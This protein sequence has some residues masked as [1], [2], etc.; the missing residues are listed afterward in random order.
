MR[1]WSAQRQIAG[2]FTESYDC[3]SCKTVLAVVEVILAFYLGRSGFLQVPTTR[4]S[5]KL[6]RIEIHKSHAPSCP[7]SAASGLAPSMPLL[8]DGHVN[9]LQ[10]LHRHNNSVRR[11]HG[12]PIACTLKFGSGQV[13]RT[14][15]AH[16]L[17][18]WEEASGM[19]QEKK[20]KGCTNATS[21]ML[22]ARGFK[23]G[24]YF[25]SRCQPS[26]IGGP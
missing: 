3:Y 22:R 25:M 19:M 26:S 14:R 20:K 7:A 6:S 1:Q 24:R 11:T 10:H 9:G 18:D 2:V 5:R 21:E 16:A 15:E 17:P 8:T 13:S 4:I 23:S 12:R